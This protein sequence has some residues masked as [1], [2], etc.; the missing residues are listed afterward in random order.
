MIR[1][2]LIVCFVFALSVVGTSINAQTAYLY[3]EVDSV[4]IGE[5]FNIKLEFSGFSEED[6]VTIDWDTLDQLEHRS[7]VDSQLYDVDF[8]L[9]LGNFKG[10]DYRFDSE[11]LKWEKDDQ[12]SPPSFY[13]N[14]E[15]TVW[16]LCILGIPGPKVTLKNGQSF[17]LG[18]RYIYVR[19]PLLGQVE[20]LAPSES[21]LRDSLIH[22]SICSRSM[23]GGY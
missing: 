9:S 11:E 19:D 8:D 10:D 13:N 21:I 23:Y 3:S 17:E 16:E 15:W 1:K 2:I 5:S 18:P 12:S 6:I 14:F 7:L 20:Q 22:L 4:N